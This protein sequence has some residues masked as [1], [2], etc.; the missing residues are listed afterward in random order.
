MATST[1]AASMTSAATTCAGTA[2]CISSQASAAG[3]SD[4][5]ALDGGTTGPS[6]QARVPVSLTAPQAKRRAKKTRATSGRRCTGSSASRA[7][8]SSLASRLQAKMP[9]TGGMEYRLTWKERVTPRRRLIYALRASVPHISANA[10]VGWATPKTR[11]SHGINTP[12]H[13]AWKRAQGHGCSDLVDQVN[14]VAGWPTATATDALK[15]G[16]VSARPGCMGLA[17]TVQLAGWNTP[18]VRDH[19]HS[20]GDGSNPRDLPRQLMLLTGWTTPSASDGDRGGR[21]TQA[22]TGSSLAQ[23]SRSITG[24]ATPAAR[25]SRYP[26]RRS[27]QERSASSKGEQLCN[28][29]VHGLISCLS[30]AAMESGVA[31]VLNPAMSRW[32]MGFPEAWDQAAPGANAWN[33]WQQKRIASV[34]SRVMETQ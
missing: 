4:F 21:V 16:R 8:Q 29:V 18:V 28:Q 2:R 23:Q 13:L 7:L 25:D 11:D 34:G 27:Y 17:E 5:A 26:N 6:V 20:L 19:M 10:C 33:S 14:T 22:M 24:W 9:C 12:E 1:P 15:C 31:L 3:R 32:L 30:P